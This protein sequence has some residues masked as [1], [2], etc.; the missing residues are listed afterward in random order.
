LNAIEIKANKGDASN[1]NTGKQ[2]TYT[3]SVSKVWY[4]H[5]SPV[6][7]GTSGGQSRPTDKFQC[8]GHPHAVGG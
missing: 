8:G 1:L 2:N 3:K 4:P 5:F 6:G 7:P